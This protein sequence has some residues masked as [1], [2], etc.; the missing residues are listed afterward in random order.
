MFMRPPP[1]PPPQQIIVRRGASNALKGK[2][3][4]AQEALRKA[5]AATKD[6]VDATEASLLT[7]VVVGSV[8]HGYARGMGYT[9]I[10]GFD[11]GLVLGA[12]ALVAAQM[13]PRGSHQRSLVMGV[14]AGMTAAV[15]SEY[16]EGFAQG[17]Q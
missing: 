14:G 7:G 1:A 9:E 13:L 5:R 2:L 16:A 6:K 10:A 4:D 17:G 11:V 3:E 8:A 12:G 15:F